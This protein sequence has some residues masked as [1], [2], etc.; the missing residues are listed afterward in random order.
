[1]KKKTNLILILIS[2]LIFITLAILIKTNNISNFDNT[3]Y[4]LVT[5]YKNDNITIFF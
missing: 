5:T 2:L 3:I 1:M 4:N